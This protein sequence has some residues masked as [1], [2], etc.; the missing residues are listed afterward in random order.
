MASTHSLIWLTSYSVALLV[1][2]LLLQVVYR[3]TF[4]PLAKF[5]G[6]FWAKISS[7]YGMTYDFS[8][9]ESYIKNFPE[10]HRKYGN[11]IRIFPNELHVLDIKA[12][13][14]IYKPGTPFDKHP[15]FYSGRFSKGLFN[16]PSTKAAK[17]WKGVYQPYFSRAAIARLEPSIHDTLSTF[18]SKLEK[19]ANQPGKVVDLSLAFRC[20]TS[21]TIMRYCFADDAFQSLEYEDFQ[22]PTL[23]AMEEAFQ[24]T[25]AVPYFPCFF[26]LI[27]DVC[28][29]LPQDMLARLV[30]AMDSMI[31]LRNVGSPWSDR[32]CANEHQKCRN[33]VENI[34]RNGGSQSGTATVFD[35]WADG[36]IKKHDFPTPPLDLLGTDALM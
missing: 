24:T 6:P 8:E 25:M 1:L 4:H 31:W 15:Q 13:Y 2:F 14:E 20:L 27:A 32:H 34:L 23:L 28:E 9:N 10:W 7:I 5:P 30:P 29:A 18:M 26:N 19:A 16:I 35:S 17:P 36:A 33:R 3:I 11:I 22:S 21:D 12:Y